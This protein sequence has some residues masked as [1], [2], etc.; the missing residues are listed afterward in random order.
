MFHLPD[1]YLPKP[2]F[3]YDLERISKKFLGKIITFAT[4]LRA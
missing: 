1:Y 4:A 3:Q 2:R